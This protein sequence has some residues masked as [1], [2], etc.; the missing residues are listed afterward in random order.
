MVAHSDSIICR[1]QAYG[2]TA[3][4]IGQALYEEMAYDGSGQPLASTPADYLLPG[5]AEVPRIRVFH[6][7]TPLPYTAHGIKGVGEGGAIGP[8]GAIVSAINDA[9]YPLGA[10]LN[11]APAAPRRIIEAIQKARAAGIRGRSDE[12]GRF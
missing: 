7:E 1:G 9:L 3:Q 10:E 5:A 4:S 12:A 6:M 11:E 2:G 8:P